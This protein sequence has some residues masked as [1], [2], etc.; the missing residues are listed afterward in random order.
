MFW[1]VVGRRSVR[2][3]STQ[4]H[5]RIGLDPTESEAVVEESDQPFLFLLLGK[6]TVGPGI[7]EGFEIGGRNLTD[8]REPCGSAPP[9]ELLLED[10]GQLVKRRV[11]KVLVPFA[12]E[13][14]FHRSFDGDG[15]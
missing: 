2:S 1:K 8:V 9:E 15:F 6:R 14:S 7:T 13:E 10:R 3:N 5:G 4:Q 11:C 12:G